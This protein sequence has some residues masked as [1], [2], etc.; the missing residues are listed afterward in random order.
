MAVG[1][2]INRRIAANGPCGS[3]QIC[4]GAV[5]HAEEPLIDPACVDCDSAARAQ[6]AADPFAATRRPKRPKWPSLPPDVLAVIFLGGCIGGYARYAI[7]DAW[8]ASRSTF[9]S[10]ILT[11]NLIG[12]FI[13]GLVVV[14][15]AELPS[16]YL[17][18]LVGTGFCGALTTFSTVVVGA[19]GIVARHRPG[20]AAGYLVATI[21]GGL[22]AAALGLAAGRVLIRFAR[23]VQAEGRETDA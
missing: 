15:A 10:A 9:P 14:T 5:A 3:F 13:L 23:G 12:A 16:R 1:L 19:A 8:T 20:V 4:G 18:P 7:S 6:P 2:A 22:A 21:V 17:R 11:V